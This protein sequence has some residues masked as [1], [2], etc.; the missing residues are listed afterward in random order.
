MSD[1]ETEVLITARAK[2]PPRLPRASAVV[3]MGSV[4]VL[5]VTNGAVTS[6]ASGNGCGRILKQKR[7][8]RSDRK[9][10]VR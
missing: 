4:Y 3:G 7:E 8:A 1:L 5:P 9:E 10:I 2:L 6:T